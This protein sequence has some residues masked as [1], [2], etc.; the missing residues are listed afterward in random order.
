MFFRFVWFQQL[1]RKIDLGYQAV[2]IVKSQVFDKF[3]EEG[4]VLP[5]TEAQTVKYDIIVRDKNG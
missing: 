3:D 2:L 1:V 4:N 5:L